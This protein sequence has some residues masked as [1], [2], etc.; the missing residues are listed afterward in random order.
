MGPR[1]F[2]QCW[3]AQVESPTPR[4]FVLHGIGQRG[5]VWAVV[6]N[7]RG[8]KKHFP[9]KRTFT[10]RLTPDS[11]KAS[12]VAKFPP[13]MELIGQKCSPMATVRTGPLGP[14]KRSKAENGRLLEWLAK[15][16]AV[17]GGSVE[18]PTP[19][20]LVLHGVGQH[21][22]VWAVVLM[23]HKKTTFRMNRTL[24]RLQKVSHRKRPN[25]PKRRKLRQIMG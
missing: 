1:M 3:A 20:S 8:E 19:R 5:A 17:L 15:D 25:C 21:W 13:D 14:R 24:S 7:G 10:K 16:W 18:L 6:F 11:P 2:G 23:A 22:A 4:S 12:K 9:Q